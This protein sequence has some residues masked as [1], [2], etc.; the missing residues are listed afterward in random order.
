MKAGRYRMGILGLLRLLVN[1]ARILWG[2]KK[3]KK[4]MRT[5][6]DSLP[7]ACRFLRT[8]FSSSASTT[9]SLRPKYSAVPALAD[10]K[11]ALE[12]KSKRRPRND[13][14]CIWDIDSRTRY[15][16]DCGLV[17]LV[18]KVDHSASAPLSSLNTLLL[19]LPGLVLAD[20]AGD[21]GSSTADDPCACIARHP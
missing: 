9:A 16:D 14:P 2:M 5:L 20:S 12:E 4:R 1:Q 6:A 17:F 8:F 3:R 7:G 13:P 15:D 18:S 10:R 21:L 11:D 19:A